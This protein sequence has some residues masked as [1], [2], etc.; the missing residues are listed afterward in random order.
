MSNNNNTIN[1]NNNNN[2]KIKNETS[3]IITITRNSLIDG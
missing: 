3:V 1:N 2:N